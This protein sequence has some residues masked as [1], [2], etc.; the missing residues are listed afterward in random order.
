MAKQKKEKQEP[1]LVREEHRGRGHG[2]TE[3]EKWAI[4]QAKLAL[5]SQAAAARSLGVSAA[6]VR[7][8]CTDIEATADPKVLQQTRE[9]ISA[10]LTAKLHESTNAI[11]D[12]IKPED[13]VTGRIETHNAEGKLIGVKEYGPTL[14]QK[15]TAAAIFTDKMKVLTDFSKAIDQ[16]RREGDL[17]MPESRDQLLHAIKNRIKSIQ[18]LNVN[19]REDNP[20]LATRLDAV[21]EVATIDAEPESDGDSR[22]NLDYQ[23]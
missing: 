13:L 17:M 10:Q 21:A 1:A 6:T 2:L 23:D 7:K 16:D 20:E 9:M 19:F 15:A 4:Y 5:G 12:S 8:V 18:V 22:L 11:I 3:P 14:L